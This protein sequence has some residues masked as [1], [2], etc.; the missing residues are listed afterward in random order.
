MLCKRFSHEILHTI[1][2]T[3]KLHA[4][5]KW[6]CSWQAI[7]AFTRVH[8]WI[9]LFTIRWWL[10]QNFCWSSLPW[11]GKLRPGSPD[12]R[13][14]ACQSTFRAFAT[15]KDASKEQIC[16]AKIPQTEKTKTPHLAKTEIPRE[17]PVAV[18]GYRKKQRLLARYRLSFLDTEEP[19]LSKT[20]QGYPN[21]IKCP[22]LWEL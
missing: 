5:G 10:Q 2:T 19:L 18:S 15:I 11:A 9:E 21:S 6:P 17:V 13:T 14:C 7:T 20:K 4:C 16:E 12:A 1:Q 3:K 22:I 8:S